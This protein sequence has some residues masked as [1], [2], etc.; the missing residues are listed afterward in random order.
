MS[1]SSF[2]DHN[3]QA[4]GIPMRLKLV[5]ATRREPTAGHLQILKAKKIC[6]VPTGNC[7]PRKNY[8][9][10]K[11][12]LVMNASS[13]VSCFDQEGATSRNEIPLLKHTLQNCK[14]AKSKIT[15]SFK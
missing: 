7:H 11:N 3:N 2:L 15:N 14:I 5:L 1:K 13:Q 8:R 12:L 9:K 10:L 4:F 6:S